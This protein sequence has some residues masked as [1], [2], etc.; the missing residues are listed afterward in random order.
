MNQQNQTQK[1]GQQG[2]DQNKD[3]N[4][5]NKDKNIG[6]GTQTKE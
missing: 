2:S 3:K 4:N 1:P 5:Q 6:G